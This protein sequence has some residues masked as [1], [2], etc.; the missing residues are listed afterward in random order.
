M[1]QLIKL[2]LILI[3]FMGQ[4]NAQERVITGKVTDLMGN[5]L[6]GV[7][8]AVKDYP[9]IMTISG[10]NGEYR[11]MAFDFSKALIFSFAGMRTEEIVVGEISTINAKLG[12]LPF[13]NPNPYSIAGYLRP[14]GSKF[15]NKAVADNEDWKIES[16]MSIMAEFNIN[17]FITS[18]IGF[19]SGISVGMYSSFMELN[20]FNN[21]GENYIER[22]DKD[23]DT[24]Y[25][26]NEANGVSENR[27]FSYISVPIVFKY[28]IR[29][30]KKI[31]FYADLGVRVLY[32]ILSKLKAEIYSNMYAYY[33]QYHVVIRRLPEY[34]IVDMNE[35]INQKITDYE[36][37]NL[38]GIVSLGTSIKFGKN[39]HFDI[40]AYFE[41]GFTDLGY[42]TPQY[43]TDFLSTIGTTGKTSIIGIGANLGIRYD[44]IKKR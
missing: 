39:L 2:S 4:I 28:Q 1:N 23:G 6:P 40:G 35:E 21:Y 20:E 42:N 22:I 16:R 44:I 27:E 34:G 31:G 8:I 17:Y 13:K 36:A 32:T 37:I 19:G 25:L 33:P 41:Y 7:N 30:H 24:F 14:V 29:Q 12:Y 3:F 11:I 10:A 38:S 15:K 26:Y 9:S 43:N 5:P 18:E